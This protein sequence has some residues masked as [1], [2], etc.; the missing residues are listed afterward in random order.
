M[1]AS[2]LKKITTEAKRIRKLHPSQSWKSAIKEAGRK[3]RTG[4]I[5]GVK[6]KRPVR[7]K[8]VGKKKRGRVGYSSGDANTRTATKA[9]T[10][11]NK[12]AT[13]TIGSLGSHKR[14]VRQLLE[15]Q[16]SKNLLAI[17]KATTKPK[18]KKLLKKK[19]QIKREMNAFK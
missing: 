11:G 7:K 13:V 10:T 16:L 19:A 12:T 5:S 15:G 4:K 8:A 6:K 2:A 9:T 18:R 14:V 1:A 17:E 3:Y